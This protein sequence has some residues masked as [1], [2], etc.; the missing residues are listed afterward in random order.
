MDTRKST[1]G[2]TLFV[3]AEEDYILRDKI[4]ERKW[5]FRLVDAMA[6]A[7][8]NGGKLFENMTFYVTSKVPVEPKLL[9]NVVAAQGG[10]VHSRRVSTDVPN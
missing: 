10:K 6:R 9:K 7:K 2:L 4:N 8:E 1:P 3:T 5:D